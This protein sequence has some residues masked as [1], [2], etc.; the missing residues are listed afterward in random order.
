[1]LTETVVEFFSQFLRAFKTLLIDGGV[2]V[3]NGGGHENDQIGSAALK[4]GGTEQGS[5]DRQIAENGN[6]LTLFA[7]SLSIRPDMTIV[8]PAEHVDFGIG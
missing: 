6:L 1:M 4:V 3:G 8:W 5:Q 7:V 2:G